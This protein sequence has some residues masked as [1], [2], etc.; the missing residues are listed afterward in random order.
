MWITGFDVPNLS[1]LY[2]DKPMKNH[3]LMQTIARTNRVYPGKT[4]GLIVD[5]I[6]VFRNLQEALA[7]YAIP[8]SDSVDPTDII[9]EKKELVGLLAEYISEAESLLEKSGLSLKELLEV[10]EME[11]IELIDKFTD[12]LLQEEETK[13][14]FLDLASK[15]ESY[16][17]SIMPDPDAED[18]YD[19]KAAIKVIATRIRTVVSENVDVSHVKKDLE[20]LL[21]KSIRAGEYR[22]KE[23]PKI[24][25]LSKINFEALKDFFASNDHKNIS[26][27]SLANDLEKKVNEMM[28]K[29]KTRKRFLERLNSLLSEYNSGSKPVDEFFDDLLELAQDLSQEDQRAI[30]EN[31]NEEELAVFDILYKEELNPDEEKRVKKLAQELLEKL[32]A[33]KLVLDWRKKEKTRAGVRVAIRDFLYD[34]LPDSY[35]EKDLL[36]LQK[37][38]Y[39]HVFDSYVDSKE[40]VYV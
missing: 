38:V 39:N 12:K 32:K 10:E 3:T 28:R 16:Y 22:I 9:Q 29:N 26:A 25:D 11:K 8:E 40:N 19:Q 33:E 4:H 6:G 35:G 13:K 36:N 30:K 34:E 21:D 2:L 37:E 24:H 15:I 31:L 20:D 14:E 18:Y 1:T 5:Y 17:N 27:E 23:Y 7:I